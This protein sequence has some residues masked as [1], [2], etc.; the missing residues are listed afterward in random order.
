MRDPVHIKVDVG[1]FKPD[2]LKLMRAA[3]TFRTRCTKAKAKGESL[4]TV[5]A[6]ILPKKIAHA[7]RRVIYL[8]EPDMPESSY[9][10]I[11]PLPRGAWRA[12]INGI[13]FAS[14]VPFRRAVALFLEKPPDG[15]DDHKVA[16]LS[17]QGNTWL[18]SCR[19]RE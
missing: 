18:L 17:I 3:K 5:E 13:T 1:L 7:L 6:G 14:A 16:Y 9:E 2:L 10:F 19:P 15:L 11:Y 4:S 8:S 12:G